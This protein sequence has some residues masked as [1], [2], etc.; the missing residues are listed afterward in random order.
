M[1][2]HQVVLQQRQPCSSVQACGAAGA[3]AQAPSSWSMAARPCPVQRSSINSRAEG[4]SNSILHTPHVAQRGAPVG[5]LRSVPHAS[6]THADAA[7]QQQH[8]GQG[9]RAFAYNL[10]GT[11][12]FTI[13]S[14]ESLQQSSDN[15]AAVLTSLLS[16]ATSSKLLAKMVEEHVAHMDA[17][18][19]AAAAYRWVVGLCCAWRWHVGA[20]DGDALCDCACT[21]DG[22]D[23][24]GGMAAASAAGWHAFIL[25]KAFF[26]L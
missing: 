24:S 25:T 4:W 12:S 21:V 3:A 11:P 14:W 15:P 18:H 7:A 16:N 19:V 1:H 20:G 26:S 23:G 5:P 6:S 10:D 17:T 2:H 8:Q 9:A 22:D 13:P